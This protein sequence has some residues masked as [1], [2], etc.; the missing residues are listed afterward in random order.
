MVVLPFLWCAGDGDDDEEEGTSKIVKTA[1]S[2][3]VN[4][5]ASLCKYLCLIYLQKCSIFFVER[6][7]Q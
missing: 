2:S 1:T 5:T 3:L 7:V 4:S 6:K